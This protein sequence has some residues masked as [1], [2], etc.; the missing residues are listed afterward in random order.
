MVDNPVAAD[1]LADFDMAAQDLAT[2]LV[3]WVV[4]QVQS[5][6]AVNAVA[7]W[8]VG[9]QCAKIVKLRA[10]NLAVHNQAEWGRINLHQRITVLLD[11]RECGL[12]AS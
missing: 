12:D 4:G 5:V 3:A 2:Q 11:S 7:Q 10:S 8:K 9:E 1:S 6:Q